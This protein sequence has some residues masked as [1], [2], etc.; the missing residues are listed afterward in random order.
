MNQWWS[1]TGQ[2]TM[3]TMQGQLACDAHVQGYDIVFAGLE[4]YL[5][6]HMI[7]PLL[8]MHTLEIMDKN[9]RAFVCNA[10]QYNLSEQTHKIHLP[11]SKGSLLFSPGGLIQL[12]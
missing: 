7:Y 11:Y 2:F 8:T 1:N 4:F 9:E 3:H 12:E 10:L 5:L 6:H